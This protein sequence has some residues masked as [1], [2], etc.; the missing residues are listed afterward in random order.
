V[1]RDVSLE[2]AERYLAD[3]VQ[4][5]AL[6]GLPSRLTGLAHGL[7]DHAQRTRAFH[8]A[9]RVAWADGSPSAAEQKMLELLQ[10]TLGLGDDEVAR[11]TAESAS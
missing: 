6:E 7:A 11:I 3:A 10:A 9:V 4:Q 2:A 8:L 5:L 1:F